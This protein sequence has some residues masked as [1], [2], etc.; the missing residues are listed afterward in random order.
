MS[1]LDRSLAEAAVRFR[2]EA[3]AEAVAEVPDGPGWIWTVYPAVSSDPMVANGHSPTMMR[4]CKC[5]EESLEDGVFAVVLGPRGESMVCRRTTSGGFHW[6][7]LF[8]AEGR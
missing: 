5:A 8:A 7:P 3:E 1:M 2:A 4:A 6:S